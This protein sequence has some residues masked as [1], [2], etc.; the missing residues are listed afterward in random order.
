MEPASNWQRGMAAID[1]EALM[2]AGKGMRLD[3]I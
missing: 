3:F 1:G 2:R